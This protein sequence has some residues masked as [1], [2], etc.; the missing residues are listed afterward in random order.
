M[1]KSIQCNIQ[2]VNLECDIAM[3]ETNC[4]IDSQ[5]NSQSTYAENGLKVVN[6]S[7]RWFFSTGLIDN[8]NENDD[9]ILFKTTKC[10]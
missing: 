9:I 2:N 8:D 10:V 7:C 6:D 5:N 3:S 4:N 1:D